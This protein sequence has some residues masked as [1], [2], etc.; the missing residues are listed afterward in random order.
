MIKLDEVLV[1][2]IRGLKLEYKE[3]PQPELLIAI[4][5]HNPEIDYEVEIITNEFT[6][7]CPLNTAQPDYATIAITYKPDK[8]CVELKSLKF[9]LVSFR[10][11]PIF[12][13]MVPSKIL[14][15]LS[16]LLKPI[17]MEVVGQFSTRGGLSTTVR[18]VYEEKE[19]SK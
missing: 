4:P 19:G 13:E 8:L 15:A 1:E 12:H 10:Q 18:A 5:N 3:R 17:N 6:S 2:K 16:E 9:F 7:L 11:V 14:A